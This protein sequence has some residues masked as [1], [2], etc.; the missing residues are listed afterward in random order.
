LSKPQVVVTRATCDSGLERS[1][2]SRRFADATL[3]SLE[4][5]T[6]IVIRDS[7]NQIYHSSAR[8]LLRWWRRNDCRSFSETFY[9]VEN[10]GSHDAMLRV[11][12]GASGRQPDRS[13]PLQNPRQTEGMLLF[14]PK[15][16][17][18]F[19]LRQILIVNRGNASVGAEA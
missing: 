14:C 1:L 17:E 15:A 2:L 11:D 3:G 4:H 12:N 19:S 16:I 13:L 10:C 5:I 6:P 18:M 8:T 7:R 9:I